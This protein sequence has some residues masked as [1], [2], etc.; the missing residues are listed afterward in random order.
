MSVT[1]SGKPDFSSEKGVGLVE[2]VIALL[3]IM[4]AALGI[5]NLQ[6]SSLIAAQASSVH[7]TL[8]QL[9]SEMLETL[10]ANSEDASAGSLDLTSEGSANDLVA[11]WGDRV[12][13]QLHSGSATI[14]CTA[15]DCE[16]SISWI[17]EI[18]G[19]DRTRVFLTRTPL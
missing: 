1:F 8:D 4:V 10:R 15:G 5:A 9:S 7:F 16:I 19:T 18:D 2:V 17:E 13:E 11:A 3:I 6:T 14:T 12:S